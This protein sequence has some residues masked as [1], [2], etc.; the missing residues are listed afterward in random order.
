MSG[1]VDGAEVVEVCVSDQRRP[2]HSATNFLENAAGCLGASARRP[3]WLEAM[4]QLR[5]KE[6]VWAGDRVEDAYQEGGRS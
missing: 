6:D 1:P 5:K 2:G 4:L 3:C